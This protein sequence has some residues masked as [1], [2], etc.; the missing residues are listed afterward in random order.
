MHGDG[1]AV[2]PA[3]CRIAPAEGSEIM[4]I[5]TDVPG[6]IRDFLGAHGAE[7]HAT[8]AESLNPEELVLWR[9]LGDGADLWA[10]EGT[11]PRAFWKQAVIVGEAPVSQFDV[12]KDLLKM[13]GGA[14]TATACAALHGRKFHGQ[15]GRPW[16]AASGNLHLCTAVRPPDMEARYALGLTMIPAVSVVRT[17][18]RLAGEG[19]RPGI[20]WVNDILLDGRKIAGVLTH[21][22]SRGSKLADIVFGIGLNIAQAPEISWTPFVPATGCLAQAGVGISLASAFDAILE[23]IAVLLDDYLR[24]G[25]G[26][27]FEMYR[28]YSL[29]VGSEVCIWDEEPGA[30]PEGYVNIPPRV[31]GIVRELLPDLSLVVE[32][33]SEP[34]TRGRLAFAQC[35]RNQE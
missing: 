4:R 27:L 17:V 30:E 24:R 7:W 16:A 8:R 33:H 5:L 21:T 9:A 29:V 10:G 35:C 28:S 22:H 15:R 1:H 3:V 31:R 13:E 19:V 32:G 26:P 12:L 6:R 23:E 2:G 25:P 11:D 34:V 20:K 14:L 18:R